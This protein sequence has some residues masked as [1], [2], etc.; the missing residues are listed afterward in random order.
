MGAETWDACLSPAPRHDALLRP[1]AVQQFLVACKDRNERLRLADKHCRDV[2]EMQVVPRKRV[3]GRTRIGEPHRIR[4]RPALPRGPVT[5]TRHRIGKDMQ[6]VDR[7][8]QI[9]RARLERRSEHVRLVGTHDVLEI[10]RRKPR[11]HSIDGFRTDVQG[12]RRALRGSAPRRVARGP[13]CR[14]PH[15]VRWRHAPAPAT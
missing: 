1:H 3:V 10:G 11:L 6:R 8:C 7:P 15:R 9:E 5:H 12:R 2:D 4:A 13:P 14:T